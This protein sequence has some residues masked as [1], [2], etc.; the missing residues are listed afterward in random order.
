MGAPV[1]GEAE[2]PFVGDA[3]GAFVGCVVGAVV[4][5]AVPGEAEPRSTHSPS[6]LQLLMIPGI[7]TPSPARWHAVAALH[8][9]RMSP[10]NPPWAAACE[11]AVAPTHESEMFVMLPPYAAV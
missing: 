8:D 4:G 7:A 2:G 10:M 9:P 11:H 6:V 3:E 5:A 1:V